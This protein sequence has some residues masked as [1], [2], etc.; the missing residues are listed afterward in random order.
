MAWGTGSVEFVYGT[1]VTSVSTSASIATDGFNADTPTEV[2]EDSPLADAVL[3][4]AFGTAPT[5]GDQVKLFRRDKQID[6][7]GDH[8]PVPDAAYPYHY[9]GSFFVDAVTSTQKL[10]LRDIPLTPRC[11]FYIQNA[12]DQATTAAAT[13]VKVTPK[14]YNEAA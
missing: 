2:V 6:G 10:I 14:S 4:V 3:S 12:T 5:A 13:T 7:A 1:P 9:V 11:E 8:A